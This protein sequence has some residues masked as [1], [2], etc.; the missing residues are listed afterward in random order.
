MF[1]AR[2]TLVV[3]RDLLGMVL[4]HLTPDGLAA[5]TIVETEAY[6]GEGDPA[7]HAARGLT[8]RNAP[9][10]GEPGHAY[11]YF[12]YGMHTL[13]NVVTEPTGTPAAVL[14]R[15]LEPIDGL[16][17]MHRRRGPRRDGGAIEDANLCRGPGN[18]T[19]A[20]GI[21]LDRNRIDLTKPG[22]RPQMAGPR[23][24]STASSQQLAV[25]VQN[26]DDGV[27]GTSRDDSGQRQASRCPPD[28]A[29]LWI[30]ERAVRAPT[31]A[32]S[33]RIG[34]RVG[35]EHDWRCY[36]VGHPCVSGPRHSLG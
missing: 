32:W 14:I 27:H 22:E 34:I 17:G 35:T 25:S 33:S 23:Q 15:A 20:M 36:V 12:T 4:V 1:Y 26:T 13:L 2:P 8:L 28:V 7:C 9:M 3:A 19:R 31:V 24:Q 18:L 21:G 5:G 16:D 6:I 29:C 10:Y 11:V 30:E